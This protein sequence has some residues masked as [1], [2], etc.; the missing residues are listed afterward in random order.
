MALN[1]LQ[2]V[3]WDKPMRKSNS[4]NET[5]T[6]QTLRNT[7]A[8]TSEVS[9]APE[10]AFNPIAL[11]EVEMTPIGRLRNRPKFLDEYDGF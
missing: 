10:S 6:V 9:K 11:H 1:E 5:I 2:A 7:A 3:N 8:S 4:Q